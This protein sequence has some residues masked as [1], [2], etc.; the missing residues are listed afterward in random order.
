M[1]TLIT[2][3]RRC[4][5]VN[6]SKTFPAPGE[7]MTEMLGKNFHSAARD[8]VASERFR[9]GRAR[10]TMA[11]AVMMLRHADSI[12]DACERRTSISF[13]MVQTHRAHVRQGLA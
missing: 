8:V 4:G 10:S 13:V 2:M 11:R 6:Q 1:P 5:G 7:K 9:R 3:G 12:T